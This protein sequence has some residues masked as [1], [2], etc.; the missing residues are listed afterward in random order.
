MVVRSVVQNPTKARK[1]NPSVAVQEAEVAQGC[2]DC[3]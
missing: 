1:W 3:R 2:R